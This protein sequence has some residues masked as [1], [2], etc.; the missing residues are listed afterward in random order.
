MDNLEK[1]SVFKAIV[2][3]LMSLM[4]IFIFYYLYIAVPIF[5]K[6]VLSSLG[7]DLPIPT[8]ILHK[9]Y[10]ALL[11]AAITCV[12]PIT[13][14]FRS[15]VNYRYQILCFRFAFISF[16]IAIGVYLFTVCAMYLPINSIG[17]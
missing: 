16:I 9:G 17:N 1:I 8:L 14:W 13:I 3:T 6:E 10:P 2:C 5:Y 15:K 7:N 11:I 4:G 12:L